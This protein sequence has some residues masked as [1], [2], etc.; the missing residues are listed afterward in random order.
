MCQYS[1]C[2]KCVKDLRQLRG[3]P[4]LKTHREGGGGLYYKTIKLR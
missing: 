3:L 4:F 1:V 2:I